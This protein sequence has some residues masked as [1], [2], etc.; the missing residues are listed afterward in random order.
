M[1]GP[2]EAV[3]ML[4][5]LGLR[6]ARQA[7]PLRRRPSC[8]GCHQFWTAHWVCR[9][10]RAH[11]AGRG[12]QG[13]SHPTRATHF[14]FAYPLADMALDDAER[15]ATRSVE[16]WAAS[17]SSVG[18]RP[19]KRKSSASTRSCRHASRAKAPAPQRPHPAAAEGPHRCA[20]RYPGAM[21]REGRMATRPPV[22]ARGGRVGIWVGCRRP[23]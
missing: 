2:P 9:R 10:P 8:R 5:K 21:D 6:E 15:R 12:A 18:S 13:S 7:A 17:F 20:P 22:A 14:A 1:S 11:T 4:D 3:A 23:V 19:A 16:P